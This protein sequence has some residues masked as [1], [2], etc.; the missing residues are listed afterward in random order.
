MVPLKHYYGEEIKR[1]QMQNNRAVT[2]YE[3]S[4]LFGNAYL[5]VQTGKIASSGFRA[6]GLHQLNRNIFED[7]D[8]NAVTE[9]HSS[10][11]GALLSRKEYATQTTSLC[12]FSSEVAGS[13]SL[14]F[15]SFHITLYRKY[16]NKLYIA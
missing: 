16:T 12:A 1:W 6:T 11:A 5:E 14:I 13:S 7:F 10:C 15:Y 9:E 3:V 2:H 4:E 8:F